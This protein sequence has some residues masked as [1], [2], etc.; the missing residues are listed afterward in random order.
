MRYVRDIPN[1]QYKIGLFQ[2]NGKYIVKIE[3]GG[4]YEQI[5]KLDETEFA[6]PEE[7]GKV[8]DDPFML[9]VTQRFRQMHQDAHESLLRNGIVF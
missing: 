8:L 6:S 5:Y 7:V 1:G 3:A 4:M 9:T 2:W